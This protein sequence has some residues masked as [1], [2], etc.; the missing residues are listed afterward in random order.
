MIN[1][2]LLGSNS[3]NSDTGWMSVKT[4]V[5]FQ[6]TGSVSDLEPHRPLGFDM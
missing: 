6:K 5:A 1:I 2:D 3:L 4:E